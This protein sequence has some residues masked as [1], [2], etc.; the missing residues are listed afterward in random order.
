MFFKDFC[1][2][3]LAVVAGTFFASKPAHAEDVAT[4]PLFDDEAP[5]EFTLEAPLTTLFG[6]LLN[7]EEYVE[8]KLTFKGA[9][10]NDG[11]EPI[12]LKVR[13][14]GKTRRSPEICTFPPLRFNFKTKTVKDTVFQGQD[15]LKLVTHCHDKRSRYQ[16][17]YRQEYYIY[18]TYSLLTDESYRVRAA[19]ITYIDTDG[20]RKPITAFAFFLED[21][22]HLADRT[23]LT[24]V[25]RATI[26]RQEYD[27]VKASRF[28][29]FQYLI[30]NLDFATL[31]GP[32]NECC[33]NS[34][35]FADV[36]GQII[37][38]PYDF[39]FSGVVNADYATP[40]EGITVRNM[41]ERIFRG[42]CWYNDTLPEA[43]SLLNQ[44]RPAIEELYEA[45]DLMDDR[46]ARKT[47]RYYGEAYKAI[48]R[49]RDWER[50][51]IKKCRGNH[52]PAQ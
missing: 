6:P 1:A 29:L 49:P 5:L 51:I 20:K 14:R 44:K 4:L 19:R 41:R 25:K 10:G 45:A 21:S 24:R 47:L 3:A 50:K 26:S 8:A 23:G 13:P 48:N 34:K 7:A 18:K 30:G 46:Q 52:K 37:S 35:P 38:V 27:E 31:G 17:Y 22:D 36:S 2:L 15:K 12:V 16:N 11:A 39:D 42:L 32:N 43:A 40:P 28:A 9:E 33:H